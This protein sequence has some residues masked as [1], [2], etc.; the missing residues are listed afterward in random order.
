MDTKQILYDSNLYEI[1]TI[2]KFVEK[3]KQNYYQGHEISLTIT[4]N[5]G[6]FFGLAARFVGSQLSDQGL[7]LGHG[8]E[9]LE[10]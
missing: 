8:S 3:E 5:I 2:H 10:S 6:F 7:N 1:P 4:R 9:S